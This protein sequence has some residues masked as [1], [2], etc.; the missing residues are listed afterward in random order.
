MQGEL[1]RSDWQ[2]IAGDNESVLL[3]SRSFLDSRRPWSIVSGLRSVIVRA[4]MGG[5]KAIQ[6]VGV[7]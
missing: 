6:E 3:T 2:S 1:K 4:S 7:H 5:Y